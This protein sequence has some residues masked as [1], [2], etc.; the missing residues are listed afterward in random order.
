[1]KKNILIVFLV[2]TNI[3]FLVFS[4]AQMTIAKQQ[5]KFANENWEKADLARQKLIVQQKTI[6]QQDSLIRELQKKLNLKNE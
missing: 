2:I 4:F 1:M 3:G 5:T 6:D